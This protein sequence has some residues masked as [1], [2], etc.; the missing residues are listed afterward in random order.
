[1]AAP[2]ARPLNGLPAPTTEFCELSATEQELLLGLQQS[3]LESV[4][5]GNDPQA[6]INEV[7]RLEEQLLPNAVASVMLLDDTHHLNVYAAPSVPPAGVSRLNGLAPGPGGGSCGNAIYRGEAVFVCDT[8]VDP[9]WENIRP[10]AQDFGLLSCWSIPIRSAGE[11]PIGTFALSSFE[12]RSPSPFHRKMLEIG[13]SIVGIVL[14]RTRQADHIRLLSKAF[15]SSN[16]AIM[17]TDAER[18]IISVNE[19]FTATTGYTAEEAVGQNPRLLSSGRH[20]KDFYRAMWQSI[21]QL[22]HWRGEIWNRRRNG[23]IYPQ[24]INIS[25]VRDDADRITHYLGVLSDITERKE[26]QDY[27]DFLSHHDALT[28]LPN[29]LLLKDRLSQALAFADRDGKK[30]A[31]LLLDIDNFKAINDTLGHGVGDELLQAAATRLRKGMRESDTICRQGGD[32]FIIALPGLEDNQA[33]CR[34]MED[35]LSRLNAPFSIRGHELTISASIGAALYPDDGETFETLFAKADM[36]MY[37]AKEAGRNTGCFFDDAMNANAQANLRLQND[38]ARALERQ[39][40]VLH[41]QPQ[42]DLASGA[43]VGVEALIRW[44]HPERGLLPPGHF[45]SLAEDSGLIV[46]IGEWVLREA[47]RQAAAWQAAGLPPLTMAVNL[48]ALQFKRGSL[49]LTVAEALSTTGLPAELLELELTESILIKDT[50]NVLQTVR[51]LKGMGI[52]LSVDDF[53]TGYS[54]LAYLK[55][56]AVHKLKIDRSFV[57]HMADNA[58]DAAIVRAIIQMA[59]SLN[60]STIAEGVEDPRLPDLLRVAGCNQ[61]QGFLFAKPLPADDVARLLQPVA[62]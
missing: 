33:V 29:R 52:Q 54:S 57:H 1:M 8:L 24:W 48:S 51:A 27:I 38:L 16:E 36:A 19:A 40:L 53:G 30:V 47:C 11:K 43:M 46:P 35:I 50:E 7:C 4:T 9:R 45:I 25:T 14:E 26:A 42:F 12:R 5:L 49:T 44:Q 17:I 58:D 41:Y 6:I 55:R 31:L 59:K 20:G 15:D 37:N 10:I 21:E 34:C 2:Q 28:G 62:P 3:I 60:L 13:A 39:E 32:E 22:G 61:A 23:E 56:F 18:R